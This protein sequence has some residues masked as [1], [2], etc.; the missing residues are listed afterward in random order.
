MR[1]LNTLATLA[2]AVTAATG[3][4]A[5]T[6]MAAELAELRARVDMLSAQL[7]GDS[8]A[9][10][11]CGVPAAVPT[12]RR[13]LKRGNNGNIGRKNQNKGKQTRS[14]V[15]TKDTK[16]K[17]NTD[18]TVEEEQ[19][20]TVSRNGRFNPGAGDESGD[21]SSGEEEDVGEDK[22]DEEK[23]SDGAGSATGE[24]KTGYDES[25]EE[26]NTTP[27]AKPISAG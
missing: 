27:A 6:A 13:F 24:G 11:A 2:T 23:P 19:A 4:T 26:E 18:K 12:R 9:T 22:T 1:L 17:T 21:E 15:S 3:N 16:L 14:A 7:V 10:A 5:E 25:G 20:K 8:A